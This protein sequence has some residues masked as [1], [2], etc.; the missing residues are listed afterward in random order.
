M[1][2]RSRSGLAGLAG[3]LAA[4]LLAGCASDAGEYVGSGEWVQQETPQAPDIP[5]PQ[6]PGP[7]GGGGGTDEPPQADDGIRATGLDQPATIAALPDGTA[8]VGE[9][10]SGQVT[11]VYPVKEM[12]QEPL[13]VVPGIDS[14]TGFGLVAMTPSPGYLE[15]GLVYAYITT[16][17]DGRV[18]SL[19]KSG[20]P[21]DIVTG[22][23]KGAAAMTFGPDGS[24]L[25]AT[26]GSG[27][28]FAGKILTIDHWGAPGPAAT[29]GI[30]MAPGVANPAGLCTDG[31]NVYVVHGGTGSPGALS[32]NAVYLV[33]GESGDS[34][35]IASAMDPLISYSGE[36][37]GAA[38]CAATGVAII[39]AGTDSQSLA[40]SVLGQDGSVTGDPTLSLTGMYG[41]L[42]AL[43]LDPINQGL[44]VGTYNRDGVGTPA[45]DD[46][47]VLYIPPPAGGGG[48]DVS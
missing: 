27:S 3:C 2:H 17:S 21:K 22:L 40:T 48:G 47:K 37:A 28:E 33:A 32:G 26:G 14:S 20:V 24:L 31:A 38:G 1:P 29:S 25:V 10:T 19:N 43:A 36:T 45:A 12:P 4:V 15:N 46:D 13:Y 11:R 18:I 35:G 7:P 34:G 5:K 44:W 16:E 42:R 23:P 41:R 9:R 39:T 8:L 6:Q 30:I